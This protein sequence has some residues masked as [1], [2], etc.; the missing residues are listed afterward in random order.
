MHR[1]LGAAEW[2]TLQMQMARAT[3]HAHSAALNTPALHL[4]WL[5][6]LTEGIHMLLCDSTA[7]VF[8]PFPL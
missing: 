3:F 4:P 2:K 7:S 1:E 5:L 6:Q 8:Q